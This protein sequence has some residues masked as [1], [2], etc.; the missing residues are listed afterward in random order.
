MFSLFPTAETKLTLCCVSSCR[1]QEAPHSVLS[2]M[3]YIMPVLEERLS[4]AEAQGAVTAASGG[5]GISGGTSGGRCPREPSEEIRLQLSDQLLALLQ[6]AAKAV[7]AYAAEVVQV[8][9]GS[10][11]GVDGGRLLRGGAWKKKNEVIAMW[12]QGKS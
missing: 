6:L 1:A 7:S 12:C 10:R 4:W 2:V 11:A 3:P 5:G 8:W 9:T